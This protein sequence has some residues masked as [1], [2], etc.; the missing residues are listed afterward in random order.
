[1]TEVRYLNKKYALPVKNH[2]FN[3]RYKIGA[4]DGKIQF[5]TTRGDTFVYL[6]PEIVET[7]VNAGY[8]IQLEDGRSSDIKTFAPVA[9]DDFSHI[10]YPDTGE[11]IEIAEH[12]LRCVN[13]LLAESSGIAVAATGAGKTIM[14][15]A[16]CDRFLKAGLRTLI[17]VPSLDLIDNT[18]NELIMMGI[19]QI[20]VLSGNEKT[21]GHPILIS[22]WQSLK[23][24]PVLMKQFNCVLVDEV[25]TARSTELKKLL[26]EYGSHIVHRYG[27][28]GTL[29]DDPCEAMNVHIALGA[30]RATVPASELIEKGWLATLDIEVVE[31][32]EDLTSEWNRYKADMKFGS[33]LTYAKF[34]Q[35]FF[36]DYASEKAYLI[37]NK[38]RLQW[39]ADYLDVLR[40][41]QGNTFVLVTSVDQGKKLAE[42]IPNSMFVHG[43]DKTKVRQAIYN[44]F[45]ENDDMLVIATVGIA[46]TGINIK[47]IFNLVFVD[48]GKSFIRTIQSIGRGLRKG[49]GKN[50][51]RVYDLTT[52]LK[53]GTKHTKDR[54]KYYA[55]AQ[56]PFK[57]SKVDYTH[58]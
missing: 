43:A 22:T 8:E 36:P 21:F 6:L 34:K 31:L 11:P 27:M 3:P 1:M 47:R 45:K 4:W 18:R 33:P 56:Y 20:G 44:L 25:H 30:V 46:S 32:V 7:L 58:L 57:V 29:P 37:K 38:M 10:I 26:V 49:S 52:D 51:L 53:Y 19:D 41:N 39:M 23:N 24:V 9:K 35:K 50:H 54:T 55:N 13:A 14:T 42:L 48:I 15:A 17:I 2:F 28:T 12:Q 5:F 40:D 16:L